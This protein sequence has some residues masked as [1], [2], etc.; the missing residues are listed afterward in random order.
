MSLLMSVR[1]LE[2][3]FS[4]QPLLV[5]VSFELRQGDRVGLVGPNGCG[6]STLLKL[7]MQQ[8][9]AD[10]GTIE[11][12]RH[13]TLGYLEQDPRF[14]PGASVRQ[15]AE[16]ALS[17]L[18]ELAE[19]SE[20]LASRI[21][22]TT[23]PVE[24]KRQA[25]RYEWL[26]SELIRRDAFHLDHRIDRVLHGLGFSDAQ[27]ELPAARLSGGETNRLLLATLLLGEPEVMLL[28]EPSNHLDIASTEWLEDFLRQTTSA[29]L[30]VSHDRYFLDAVTNQTFELIH[31]TIDAYPAAFS[32]YRLLREER[33]K[34]QQRTWEKQ[35][36]EIARIEDF[37]RRN[38]AGQKSAQAEDRR[39]KLE[40]I[41]RVAAPR[42][43]DV[44]P[45]RFAEPSRTGDIVLRVEQ[46]AM[47]FE[48]RT[49]FSRLGFQIER[50]QRWG[51]VGSN[52]C[53][54]STLLKG[55]LGELPPAQGTVQ[56]G[57]GVQ[58]GYF[59]QRQ[60]TLD[61][62]LTAADAIRPPHRQMIDVQ[63]RD[64]LAR[65]GIVGDAAIRP[66]RQLSGGQRNRVALA[67]LAAL[68]ANFLILDE[69][70][71][72][73]DLWSRDALERALC[74]FEGTVLVVS[75]DRYFLNQVCTH[76]LVFQPG[77]VLVFHGTWDEYR[78]QASGG[79][80]SAKTEAARS[81]STRTGQT[82]SV[83]ANRGGARSDADEPDGHRNPANSRS[84]RPKRKFPYR[85]VADIE[86]EIARREAEVQQIHCEL[87]RP[88]VLRDGPQVVRLQQ[89]LADHQT[90]LGQLYEHW[91]EACELNG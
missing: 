20:S 3:K 23:D 84:E 6:K 72:H 85:K 26:Q 19:E 90:A 28:D 25:T 38:H 31:G 78:Y 63:R 41:E 29:F 34:V 22:E 86:A 87:T 14:A 64:L 15:V 60:D 55:L 59:D 68:D 88:A 11:L 58:T 2:K 77:K 30:L 45:M 74:E 27:M 91:Q 42:T 71:N 37:I 52:G 56:W 16:A 61:S 48:G 65:F 83:P 89:Q 36:E 18:R 51:I 50:G 62:E 73:L 81:T 43:I 82:D 33:C 80:E 47:G 4:E 24:W 32:R 39:K 70:T 10:A 9:P 79:S 76:L 1:S 44:P 35:Q 49:L 46:L 7:L 17:H 21:S 75:H 8:L 66:T 69:P 5:D 53:G 54:K 40:R 13:A 67:K 12:A 57:T